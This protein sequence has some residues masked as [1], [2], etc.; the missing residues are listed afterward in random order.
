MN[1]PEVTD[2]ESSLLL[3]SHLKKLVEL[4]GFEGKRVSAILQKLNN[5][6]L[7]ENQ[8]QILIESWKAWSS[9]AKRME[10]DH[11]NGSAAVEQCK[12]NFLAEVDEE[13]E[14]QE[15]QRLA[16]CRRPTNSKEPKI[17]NELS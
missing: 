12:K 8:T 16:E 14:R 2:R 7:M 13:I 11:E 1:Y 17:Q 3:L 15:L 9:T 6:A 5:G 4:D 10:E